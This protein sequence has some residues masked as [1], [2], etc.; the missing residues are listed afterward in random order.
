MEDLYVLVCRSLFML[1]ANHYPTVSNSMPL[2]DNTAFYEEGLRLIFS[3]NLHTHSQVLQCLSSAPPSPQ[4][5]SQLSTYT[6]FPP[7]RRL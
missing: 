4:Q 6:L 3:E 5:C 7:L 1:E 2:H